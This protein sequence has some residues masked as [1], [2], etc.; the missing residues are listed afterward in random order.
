MYI[1]S[2]IIPMLFGVID[3]VQPVIS[4]NYGSK[5]NK[6]IITFFK[7]TCTVAISISI[8]TMVIIFVFPDFLVRLF[9]SKSDIA[10]INMAK[11][12]LLLYAPSYLFTWFIMTVSGLLTGLEK[13]TSS[14]V[15]MSAESIVLP[16][17]ITLILTRFIDVEKI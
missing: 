17:L 14:I 16:L 4:Y 10:V 5:N 15:L 12:A 9:S 6:R 2:L 3:S 13:A 11:I 7:I 8:I 1:E